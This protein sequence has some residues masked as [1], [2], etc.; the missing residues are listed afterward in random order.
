MWGLLLF[1]VLKYWSTTGTH[2]KN[3]P[4]R[5]S[6]V[7]NTQGKTALAAMQ[8]PR[9]AIVKVAY[10]SKIGIKGPWQHALNKEGIDLTEIS[11]A[12]KIHKTCYAH[13]CIYNPNTTQKY[14]ATWN[15]QCP[16]KK[17]ALFNIYLHDNID[18][19]TQITCNPTITFKHQRRNY[20]NLDAFMLLFPL[21]LTYNL[22]EV[23]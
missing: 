11:V 2:S 16:W 13:R 20:K 18:K 8:I 19:D 14:Q 21:L 9:A 1:Y 22:L 5:T 4:T 3:V 10:S 6:S 15:F 7:C 12:C 23:R 17:S